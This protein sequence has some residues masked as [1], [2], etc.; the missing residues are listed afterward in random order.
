[1]PD[2]ETEFSCVSIGEPADGV[3][4]FYDS[5]GNRFLVYKSNFALKSI[6]ATGS[7]L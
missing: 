1:M 2:V 6:T 3:E 7:W 4:M 5:I